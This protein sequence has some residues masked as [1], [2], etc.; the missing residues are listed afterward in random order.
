MNIL[1][2]ET[3]CDET[4]AA[5]VTSEQRVLSNVVSTQVAI[6]RKYGG[7]VPELASRAHLEGVLPIIDLALERAN[8]KLFR[9]LRE[10]K[11]QQALMQTR[12]RARERDRER[13][14]V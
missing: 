13:E 5:V 11:A 12:A 2:L 3:S 14:R 9:Q 6:H 10:Q 7:V 1:G 4:A 8:A